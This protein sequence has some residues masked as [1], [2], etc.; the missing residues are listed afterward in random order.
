VYGAGFRSVI[1]A[2]AII[3]PKAELD[4]NVTVGPFAVI[5][6]DVRIGKGTTI[7]PNTVIQSHTTIGNDNRIFQFASIGDA[8]QDKKYAGEP[9]RLEIG[10]RNVIR[11][12]TTL[13]RGT[14]QDAG[15]TRIGSDNLFMAYTHVAHDCVI[16]DHVIMANAASL[17]GHVTIEDWAIL[18]GFSIVH[19]FCRI[20]AHSFSAM[21]TAIAKDVPPYIM[22]GGHPAQPHG[23]NSEGLR[24]R[25]FSAEAIVQ[26]KR[27][28]KLIYKE[29]RKL[30][31]AVA[32][33]R[34]MADEWPEIGRMYRF[35]EQ[36]ERSIVR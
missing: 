8:P 6:P 19:Q 15:V 1:D 17:G 18:G 36:S 9:T 21:G 11:E 13:N 31:E 23:I 35:L 30:S 29:K 28:Y 2:R 33:L 16:G 14:A 7:G 3:D 25:D 5:G 24:R 22:V 12:F 20:G 26:I 4:E 10:D 34:K 27:A 32:A